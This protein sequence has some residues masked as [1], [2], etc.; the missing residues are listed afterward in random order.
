MVKL[1]DDYAVFIRPIDIKEI[2]RKR[3]L[4]LLEQLHIVGYTYKTCDYMFEIH[5]EQKGAN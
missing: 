2:E 3:A 4:N 1:I 5:L